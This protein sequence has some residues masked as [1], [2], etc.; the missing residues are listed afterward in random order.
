M[1]TNPSIKRIAIAALCAFTLLANQSRASIAYGSINNFDT[2]N[3]TGH[4]CHGFEIEIED[5]HST[6]ITYTYDYN[7]YGT[8]HITEDNL[9]VGHPKTHIRWESKKNP[10]GTWAARTIIPTGPIAATN[11]HLFT[12]PSVNFGGEHFGVGY[13][14]PA[15]AVLYNWL[16]DDG[17]GNLV[18][19][20]AVQVSTPTFTYY[21]PV[22]F[23]NLAPPQV[24]AVIAPPPPPVPEPLEF[25]KAVWVKEIRTSSHNN[26]EV[27]LRDLL[28]DDPADPNDKNWKNGEPDEVE[29]DWQVLQKDYNKA[30][31][32]NN[33][34][35][36]AAAEDLPGGDEVITRRYEFY[37]YTGP[38]DTATGEAMG[39]AV[40][41]DEVH[42]VG[43]KIINGVE[44]DLSTVEVVG[45]FTGSQMA[46]LDVDAP[47]G[48]IDHVSEG[49]VNQL[50]A[51]RTL[52]VEGALPFL[53]IENGALPTGMTFDE[54]TGVLSG[55]PTQSGDFKFTVT[56]TDTLNPDVSKTYT[57]V[58]A[59]VGE[60]LAPESMVD[61]IASPLDSG[62]TTGDGSFATNSLASVTAAP[63][64]GYRFVNWTDNG[65]VVSAT[66]SYTF[67]ILI[68]RSLT[69]NFTPDVPRY[70]IV[71]SASPVVGGTTSGGG[72]L[73]QAS[74][75][76]VI[77]TP[78][79]GYAFANWT[80]AGA[81]VSTVASYTFPV[82]AARTLVA[83]FTVLP[84][85][86]ITTSHSPA[87]GGST[88]GSG[89]YLSGTLATV[90]ATPAAGYVFIKWTVNGNPVSSLASYN[91]SVTSNKALVANFVLAGAQKTIATNTNPL[92]G[93]T[94][95]GA[96]NYLT[97]DSATVVATANPGYKFSKWQEGNSNVSSSASYTFTVAA[98]RTLT[99]R[100]IEA[101][102]INTSSSPS[103]AGTT[104]M[105]SL[106]YKTGE[107][108][109]AT[110]T[111][112]PGY[113]FLNW[114]ENGGV[115]STLANYTFTV[116]TARTLVAN[117]TTAYTITT[118][119]WPLD[120]GTALGGATVNHG[121]SITLVATAAEGHS[122]INWTDVNGIAVSVN[123]SYTFTPTASGDF[124]ANFS[125]VLA[126]VHFN[127]DSGI[128]LLPL[129]TA[130]PFAQTV[131]GLTA[132]ITS[133]DAAPPTIETKASTGYVLSKFAAHFIAPSAAA[134][135]VI[136]IR[137]DQPISGASFSF[138]TVE[139]PTVA[140]GSNVYLAAT[141][142]SSGQA[143]MVGSALAHG[144]TVPGDTFPTGT[145]TFNSGADFDTLRIELSAFPAGA[146][147][148]LLDNLIVSPAG[149]TGGSML[150]ANPDWNIT[151]SDF[152]YSD[153][154]LDNTPGFEGR[155]YLSGEWGS[156][157][158]Y[159]K[160]G[161]TVPPTWLEPQFL[162]PDWKTNSDFKVAQGI[163]LVGTNP[164]GLPIAESI[165][166]NPDIEITLHFE[167][168]DTVVGT[169]MGT[170]RASTGGVG[171]AF[172][173]NRYVL[174]QSFKVRNISGA[175]ITGVQ[176]FQLMHGL[177][178]QH[179][180]YDSRTY[181][182]KLSQYHYDATLA[183]V[184]ASS[185]GS[186]SSTIGLE[187]SIAFHSKVAPTAFEIGHYG[188][189]GNGQDNHSNGK[190]SDG[191]HLSIEDNW[192]T[193]PFN[194]RRGTDSFAPAD[195]WV[196]GG[197][198][199]SVGNLASGQFTN[200]DIVLSLLTGT[201][202]SNNGGNHNGGSCNG[203]SAHVGGV[204]FDF[205]NVTSEGTFYG[206]YSEA[207]EVE[208]TE[209]KNDG[210]FALPT[211]PQPIG[212]TSTQLWNLN[213]S[214]SHN[215][216][217]HLTF[218]YDPTLLPA[219]FN[220]N[221]LTIYHYNGV[222]WEKLICTVD[223]VAHKIA[224]SASSLS[225][226]ALGTLILPVA[227]ASS[228]SM[229]ANSLSNLALTGSTTSGNPLVYQVVAPPAHG[230]LSGFN[231]NTGAVIYTPA[232]G[233]TGIDSF[234][235]QVNDAPASSG[236]TAVTLTVNALLDTDHDGLPDAWE[237]L[238]FNNATGGIPT[239]DSDGDGISNLNEYLA[240]TLP[241]NASSGFKTTNV[242]QNS[243]GHLTLT[244]ASVGGVR[245]RVQYSNTL[246][247]GFTDIVRPLSDEF[248]SAPSGSPSTQTFTDDFS[249][250]GGAPLGGARFY[251]VKVAP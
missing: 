121:S 235:F 25:G 202:I 32:G 146:Q 12:N 166:A 88:T 183:G 208:M 141:D 158:S 240:N 101:F 159:T 110:A 6:D 142:T 20:G 5:C 148:L 63:V 76:T 151:L 145:L 69:A 147:K 24:Q 107:S 90:T 29:V 84:T 134:G 175:A 199:W 242:T 204:D 49:K 227:N 182:G 108:A 193:S 238:H 165:I 89:S 179:G 98:N 246:T 109:N 118:S 115:V 222:L 138:A 209:R 62:T 91:F 169:P 48:L 176:L 81:T 207:D 70:D 39:D 125:A 9:I 229:N 114:T 132:S 22:N 168:I 219:G 196:A 143:V 72:L 188:I 56:A 8:S 228:A 189:E 128:P 184:D 96:G 21:P 18:H 40:A 129:H 245:Y 27:K 167:M 79:A 231:A 172:N 201:K 195:R 4:E 102:V 161:V 136:E 224:T 194:T 200:F 66:P 126:G 216:L 135:T 173:S 30:D 178:S 116:T 139:D 174:N 61:T 100:F 55:T 14:V 249:R 123:P 87:A 58:I 225:P 42:G 71:T 187:D 220:E 117:F 113:H 152:G 214:G 218:A 33:N 59:A 226:F 186:G 157:I 120:G 203:G 7:H 51:A 44:V 53:C 198:R 93:G 41:A 212:T 57:L 162:Y 180:V 103:A 130:A 34:Q 35:V 250:T 11:G 36:A 127:F 206:D 17:A 16:I 211:F 221:N 154:L 239:L 177:T 248:D 2:V 230:L 95:S 97:S 83:N 215:G 243:G 77:A 131:G 164:D 153:Y 156:A 52:V 251:R 19:G 54:A 111:A 3:D 92:A 10:D 155:E 205:D 163:H 192:Q 78:N 64:A 15:T 46:A 133:P 26:H 37:K 31:G 232:Y 67:T 68:N 1:K 210:Q 105:D 233:F 217:I 149:S 45:A 237:Q 47:V 160:G 106:T 191:V 82:M 140:V 13:R 137:F 60:V 112:E 241:N 190:P 144:S 94:T 213:Y 122:F 80:E 99:A 150:L 236:V 43:I 181:A 23:G 28:S 119:G 75:A 104:E 50:Y 65:A 74:N 73:D 86:V 197:Q 85:Y 171:S 38:I 124:T 185:A 223:P 170:T 244:W 234:T 247:S